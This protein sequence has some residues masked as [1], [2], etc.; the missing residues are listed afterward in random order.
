VSYALV[1]LFVLSLTGA[2]VVGT[3]WLVGVGPGGEYRTYQVET[4]ESVAGLTAESVVK[5]QGVDVGRV[6]E[7]RLDREDPGRVRLLLDVRADAPVNEDTVARLA[8][9]GLTGL[10]YFV[11]LRGGGPD[12]APLRA[13]PGAAYPEIPSEPS[14][15]ARLEARATA[16]LDQAG[17]LGEELRATLAALRGTLGEENR[18]VLAAILAEAER[19]ARGLADLSGGLRPLVDDLAQ[20]G[21]G[22]P[23]LAARADAALG[24]LAAAS[25]DLS[26]AA[27]R[28]DGLLEETATGL[29]SLARNGLPR[30]GPLLGALTD[31][32][33]RLSRLAGELE[34]DPSLLWRGRRR[35]PGP[36]EGP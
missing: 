28:L 26:R 30:V 10:V 8:S 17:T 15:T 5:Y 24:D 12:S 21:A 22:L 31:L 35:L 34:Q 36:G 4:R 6:R 2:L 13:A 16:L 27:R 1:G 20:A 18:R 25:R 32:T 11:E 3:L 23:G 19:A 7:I 14:L 29:E 9:Q 33:D